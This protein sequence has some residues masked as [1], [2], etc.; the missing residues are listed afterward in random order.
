[1]ALPSVFSCL[2]NELNLENSVAQYMI[3]KHGVQ[4][5]QIETISAVESN[6][7]ASNET[8]EGSKHS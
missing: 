6:P 4:T 8:M 3:N 1:M 2:C 5:D 7:I